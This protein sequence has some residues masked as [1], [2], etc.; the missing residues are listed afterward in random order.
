M[1]VSDLPEA[2]VTM[3]GSHNIY[4][5][6]TWVAISLEETAERPKKFMLRIRNS[7]SVTYPGLA[8][9]STSYPSVAKLET[10][11]V[12]RIALY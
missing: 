4:Q 6:L 1:I 10:N 11:P 9:V 12:L 2:G 7:H 8:W 3:E 5:L